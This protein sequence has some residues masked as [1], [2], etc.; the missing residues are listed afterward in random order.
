MIVKAWKNGEEVDLELLNTRG[1]GSDIVEYKCDKCGSLHKT[2]YNALKRKNRVEHQY[3]RS[4]TVKLNGVVDKRKKTCVLKYGVANPMQVQEFKDKYIKHNVWEDQKVDIRDIEKSFS[5]EGY[6]L[7]ST[8]YIG[9]KEKLEFICSVG[10]KGTITWNSWSRGCRCNKCG[11][12]K[13]R[14][15]RTSSEEYIIKFLAKS[16]YTLLSTYS[17][18]KN[19]IK[20]RCPKGHVTSILFGNFKYGHRC[21]RCFG[22]AS[23]AETEVADFLRTYFPDLIQN[24]RSL[25][26]PLELDIV[27]PEKKIAIE[28]CGLYWHSEQ[29]GKNSDYH[30]N[31]LLRC[32]EIGYTLITIFEDEWVGKKD[33][34][35]SRL[36]YLLGLSTPKRVYARKC[37]VREIPAKL[38]NRFLEKNHIQGQDKSNVKLGLFY[39]EKL[40][41]VMTFGKANIAKGGID[42]EGKYE[43]VRFCSDSGYSVIGAAGKLLKYF[44]RSFA[45]KEIFSYSDKRWSVGNL[46]KKLSFEYAHDTKPNY[47]YSVNYKRFHRFNFRKSMLHKRL[48]NFD[49]N[50]TEV[51]NMVDHGYYRI[52]DCGNTKWIKYY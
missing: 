9:N 16:G 31:K 12:E 49:K 34:N 29:Q 50:K 48:Q 13:A 2:V 46:Y 30:L 26:I 23:S 40:V 7:L 3:C 44:E 4:C 39:K 43:L 11:I 22:N 20:V 17:G 41:S 33:I 52:F 27:I 8:Q 47:W 24:D 15:S 37:S 1:H 14:I 10:H 38:K 25:I 36:L 32:E 6:K 35:K 18:L 21:G 19:K 51:Q 5:K 42:A 45:P 28:Y